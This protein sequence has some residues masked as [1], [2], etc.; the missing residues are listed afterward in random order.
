MLI[1]IVLIPLFS[2]FTYLMFFKPIFDLTNDIKASIKYGLVFSIFTLIPYFMAFAIFR[3]SSFKITEGNGLTILI[4][5]C[6]SVPVWLY[7]VLKIFKM[8][9]RKI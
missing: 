7:V 4:S 3:F 2:Y 9:S 5:L 8:Y 1:P 6:L